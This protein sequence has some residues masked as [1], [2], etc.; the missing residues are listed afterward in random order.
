M[1][2]KKW[3]EEGEKRFSP[4]LAN[5]F[6]RSDSFWVYYWRLESPNNDSNGLDDRIESIFVGSRLGRRLDFTLG[7]GTGNELWT[8]IRLQPL[9]LRLLSRPSI[10]PAPLVGRGAHRDVACGEF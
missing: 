4:K 8:I 3:W 10:R 7:G 1:W 5:I 6:E 2:Q 9:L